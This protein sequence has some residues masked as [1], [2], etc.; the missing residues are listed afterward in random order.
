M[1]KEDAIEA[2]KKKRGS[3][4]KMT[5]TAKVIISVCIIFIISGICTLFVAGNSAT[6]ALT[7]RFDEI[8]EGKNPDGSPFEI[9]EALMDDVLNKAIEKLDVNLTADELRRH[10]TVSDLVDKHRIEKAKENISESRDEYSDFPTT[11]L[12][13]YATVSEQ[14]KNEGVFSAI[15]EFF[16]H[17]TLPSKGKILTAISESA[18]EVYTERYVVN[19][20]ALSINWEGADE[21]DYYNRGLYARKVTGRIGRLVHNEYLKDAS[22]V[23]EKAQSGFGDIYEKLQ[24]INDIYIENFKSY[25]I[26]NGVTSNREALLG[27]FN[28]MKE[29]NIEIQKRKTEEYKINKKAIEMYDPAVTKVVFIPSLDVEKNFYMNRTKVGMDYLV[30]GANSSKKA[31]DDAEHN[32]I[33]Y[34]YLISMFSEAKAADEATFNKADALYGEVKA[35]IDEVAAEAKLVFEDHCSTRYETL[36]FDKP[37][38]GFNLVSM[39]VFGGKLFVWLLLVAF[40]LV[41]IFVT[42]RKAVIKER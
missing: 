23:S 9:S 38:Y 29:K 19:S 22:F 32:V 27:Q 37:E 12:I 36:N 39:I 8:F 3:G 10:L 41:G 33:G 14:I 4:K 21:L 18:T 5:N 1:K 13:K 42:A 26:Q 28:Y 31:A 34:N 2:V 6:V 7:V 17:L 15:G 11:Y 40:V 30:E 24:D 25:V 16:M 20:D 35:K